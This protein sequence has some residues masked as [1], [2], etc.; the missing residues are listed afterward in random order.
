MNGWYRAGVTDA[1]GT[2]VDMYH[3]GGY[4]YGAKCFIA[5]RADGLSFV[6]LT[7]G[8]RRDLSGSVQGVELN[9]IANQITAWPSWDLFPDFSIPPFQHNAG[10]ISGYGAGCYGS[11][12]YPFLNV[13]GTPEVGEQLTFR[14]TNAAPNKITLLMLGLNQ[15]NI[16]LAPFG[17]NNCWLLNDRIA[18][19][20]GF[21]NAVGAATTSWTTPASAHAIGVDLYAQ[22]AILDATA[23]PLGIVTTAGH[24]IELG[25][26]Q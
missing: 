16:S 10:T 21:S 23:N 8:D 1:F 25:G 12:G 9:N 11:V 20:P 13:F 5:R 3:H 22:S 14:L 17:A 24:K 4:L 15:T 2:P 19:F 26:W 18:M 6:F 7:N